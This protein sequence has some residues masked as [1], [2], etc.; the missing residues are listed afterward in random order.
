MDVSSLCKGLLDHS[1]SELYQKIRNLR[2]L[3][4]QLKDVVPKKQKQKTNKIKKQSENDIKKMTEIEK[5]RL[6]DNLIK[7]R[8]NRKR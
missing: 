1:D 5:K 7:L 3:R 4:R 8:E 6:L 2:A